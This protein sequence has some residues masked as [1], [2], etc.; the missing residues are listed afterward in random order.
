MTIFL[1]ETLEKHP[2]CQPP[3]LSP[4]G[5]GR[6]MNTYSSMDGRLGVSE[7]TLSGPARALAA[8]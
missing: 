8:G 2:T 6:I 4:L 1:L 5:M 7:K 3:S